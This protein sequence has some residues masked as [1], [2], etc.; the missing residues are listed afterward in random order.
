M[1]GYSFYLLKK[2]GS[3]EASERFRALQEACK[4]KEI[5][6]VSRYKQKQVS[7]IH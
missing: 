6:F 3:G 5:S 2:V 1:L 7:F 4:Y